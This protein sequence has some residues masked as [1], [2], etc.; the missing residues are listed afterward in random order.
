MVAYNEPVTVDTSTVTPKLVLDIDDSDYDAMY[1]QVVNGNEV[2]FRYT[3][4]PGIVD[5]DGIGLTQEIKPSE[6]DIQDGGGNAAPLSFSSLTLDLS[7]VNVD[8]S[9][10]TL[11]SISFT[12]PTS[13]L[14]V[15]GE[16][17]VLTLNYNQLVAVAGTPT[18]NSPSM[19]GPVSADYWEG[20]GDRNLKF[21]Y[22]IREGDVAAAGQ[23]SLGSGGVSVDVNNRIEDSVIN[24]NAVNTL[25]ATAP[26]GLNLIAIDGV[27]PL[28]TANMVTPPRDGNYGESSV[29]YFV[30]D[31]GEGVTDRGFGNA[32]NRFFHWGQ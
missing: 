28:V 32:L 29:L 11:Q 5:D 8:G 16:E 14:Y 18:W 22:I 7:G 15:I 1:V 27:R 24:A 9:V 4:G 30:L 20:S 25:P 13:N 12:P 17:L 6:A 23:V 26:V 21:R 10:A 3:V 31:F 2:Q 19:A